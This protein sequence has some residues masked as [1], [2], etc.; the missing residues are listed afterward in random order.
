VDGV[1]K[2]NSPESVQKK[3]G[4]IHGQI[5]DDSVAAVVTTDFL[6]RL[7]AAGRPCPTTARHPGNES[8]FDRFRQQ[9]QFVRKSAVPLLQRMEHSA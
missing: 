7:W 5:A 8:P 6:H 2:V 1:W 4:A 3:V 9:A